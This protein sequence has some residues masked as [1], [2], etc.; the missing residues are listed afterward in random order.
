MLIRSFPFPAY[1]PFLTFRGARLTSSLQAPDTIIQSNKGRQ[2]MAQWEEETCKW[3][4][5]AHVTNETHVRIFSRRS[6]LKLASSLFLLLAK[7]SARNKSKPNGCR[8]WSQKWA[9]RVPNPQHGCTASNPPLKFRWC[10][11]NF[12]ALHALLESQFVLQSDTLRPSRRKPWRPVQQPLF[13]FSRWRAASHDAGASLEHPCDV[14]APLF[15]K[16]LQGDPPCAH[17][18]PLCLPRVPTPVGDWLRWTR[19][20]LQISVVWAA[21]FDRIC[22][23]FPWSTVPAAI[24][25]V[26]LGFTSHVSNSS[27]SSTFLHTPHFSTSSPLARHPSHN[28]GQCHSC[29]T[30]DIA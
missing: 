18:K 26:S 7:T 29:K 20:L 9:T 19:F 8:A 3:H 22:V 17:N 2:Q 6:F 27:P 15:K 14:L 11:S 1:P 16:M 21:N 24:P 4:A 10:E 13:A 28:G 5:P 23:C 12:S 30:E 25:Q